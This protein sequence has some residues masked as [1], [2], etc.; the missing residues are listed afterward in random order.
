MLRASRTGAAAASAWKVTFGT[1]WLSITSTCNQSASAATARSASA[2][3]PK[4]AD[5]MLGD[6]RT[7]TSVHLTQQSDVHGVGAVTV[8][9]QLHVEVVSQHRYAGKQ[10]LGILLPDV[11]TGAQHGPHPVHRLRQVWRAGGIEHRRAGQPRVH[12]MGEQ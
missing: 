10:R 6:I 3:R 12:R 5:R 7:L 2:N 11:G 1:K 4:S 9:P 8:R